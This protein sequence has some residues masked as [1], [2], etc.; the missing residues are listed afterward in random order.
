M[1]TSIK[2]THTMKRDLLIKTLFA[3]LIVAAFSFVAIPTRAGDAE[4]NARKAVDVWEKSPGLA[5]SEVSGNTYDNSFGLPFAAP[6]PFPM[7]GI[8]TIEQLK[9]KSEEDLKDTLEQLRANKV[10]DYNLKCSSQDYCRDKIA[11]IKAK[12][13]DLGMSFHNS[14]FDLLG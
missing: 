8:D 13:T 14:P 9:D 6:S 5:R 10:H 11:L 1:N 7:N 3:C 2:S 4:E 12:L